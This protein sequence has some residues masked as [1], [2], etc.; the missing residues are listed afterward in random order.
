MKL[1]L[2]FVGYC[3]LAFTLVLFQPFGKTGADSSSAVIDIEALP[4]SVLFSIEN[5]KPGDWAPR[6]LTVKNSGNTDFQ[7]NMISNLKSG[8][9][10]LYAQLQLKVEDSSGVLYEGSMSEFDGIESRTLAASAEEKLKLTVEF[11]YESGNEYQGLNAESEI[12]L[13][14][15][16]DEPPTPPGDG[17]D[18]DDGG[19]DDGTETP[20]DGTLPIT[21]EDNPAILFI[22]GFLLTFGGLMLLMIK[23]SM[24]RN[25][26]KRG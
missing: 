24:I 19:G 26:F 6:E 11:P 21:G 25:P 2:L 22:S 18:G 23:K 5:F 16:G 4:E 12:I 9:E 15:E 3:L 10:K 17:D 7:Y 13:Y 8:S 1:K 20:D 14:A